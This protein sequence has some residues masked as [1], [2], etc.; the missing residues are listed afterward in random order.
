MIVLTFRA[1]VFR[2][3][4]FPTAATNEVGWVRASTTRLRF[5]L[6]ALAVVSH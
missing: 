5:D 1:F 6:R 3:I 2:R 4:D